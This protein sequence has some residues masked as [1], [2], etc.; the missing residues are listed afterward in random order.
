[1][2]VTASIPI[3]L[4]ASAIFKSEHDTNVQR[5]TSCVLGRPDETSHWKTGVLKQNKI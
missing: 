4:H 2:I 5:F 1:M 3:I